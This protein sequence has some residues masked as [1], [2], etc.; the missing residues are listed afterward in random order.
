M[1]WWACK[2][3]CLSAQVYSQNQTKSPQNHKSFCIIDPSPLWTSASLS[4]AESQSLWCSSVDSFP[5]WSRFNSTVTVSFQGTLKISGYYASIKRLRKIH[6]VGTF[7][8]NKIHQ[9]NEIWR[10]ATALKFFFYSWKGKQIPNYKS[11]FR[12]SWRMKL[13]D[14]NP[15]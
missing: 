7:S 2:Q 11:V 13:T 3:N 14:V 1:S 5:I 12:K 4:R 6:A 15:C 10:W 9:S 8:S